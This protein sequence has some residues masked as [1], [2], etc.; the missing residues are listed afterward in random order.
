MLP[1]VLK[2]WLPASK[3]SARRT[4][5]LGVEY[6]EERLAPAPLQD[7]VVGRTLSAY[8]VAGVQNSRLDVTYTVY[9]QTSDDVTG[10]LLTTTLQSGAMFQSASAPPDR[11]G[12]NLA[13][14]I[15]TVP[16]FGR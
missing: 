11:S 16:G 7:I 2:S 5:R 15:G 3:K 13:W 6:L 14:S 1:N 10:V 4:A 12:Q 8:T 9:N